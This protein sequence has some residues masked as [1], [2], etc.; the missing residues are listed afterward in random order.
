[1]PTMSQSPSPGLIA[2]QREEEE[3]EEEEEEDQ[4]DDHLGPG[5]GQDPL[6]KLFCPDGV[7]CRF[8]LHQSMTPAIRAEIRNKIE[9]CG[10]E[11]TTL[12]RH[13]KIILVAENRLP[14]PLETLQLRYDRNED[15]V[16]Q[17]IYV[18]PLS[19]IQRC[20]HM[21]IFKLGSE[22]TIKMGMPGPRPRVHGHAYRE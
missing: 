18:K 14:I 7:P 11:I 6:S 19:Y 17:N 12:E 16:L 2:S 4:L 22:K 3:E 20:T 9:E 15:E 10:G 1:L 21:G 8:F 13:A 5:P